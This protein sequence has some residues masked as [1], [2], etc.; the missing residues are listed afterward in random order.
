M[1]AK[2]GGVQGLVFTVYVYEEHS[3]VGLKRVDYQPL[4]G[5]DLRLG[6]LRLGVGR[7]DLSGLSPSAA[8]KLVAASVVTELSGD[9]PQHLRA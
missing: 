2:S 5:S 4:L 1:Q 7:K 3:I 8:L 9:N 6:H